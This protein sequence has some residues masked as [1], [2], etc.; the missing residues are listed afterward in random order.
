MPLRGA[1]IRLG[2]HTLTAQEP[3][4]A[5]LRDALTRID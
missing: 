4:P 1:Q 3:L 2:E 5:D